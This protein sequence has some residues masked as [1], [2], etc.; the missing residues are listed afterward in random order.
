EF[1]LRV[2]LGSS[3]A[4]LIRQL[5]VENTVLSL[6]GGALGAAVAWVSLKAVLK[7]TFAASHSLQDVSLDWRVL[8]FTFAMSLATGLIFGVLPV[9]PV[10]RPALTTAVREWGRSLTASA[11][12]NRLRGAFVVAQVALALV[13]LTG[14]GLLIR[15]LVRLNTTDTGLNP[16]NVAVVRVPFS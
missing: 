3:R 5:L 8:A 12:S 13:L 10:P 15:T 16:Q 2:S 9:M 1:A 6:T 11:S 7:T 4:R 14:S